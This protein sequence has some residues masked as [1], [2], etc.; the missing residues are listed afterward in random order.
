M[1]TAL[2]KYNFEE[3]KNAITNYAIILKDDNYYFSY[4]WTLGDFLKRGI[5]KF[6]DLE[7][8]KNNYRTDKSKPK[9][10]A[11]NNKNISGYDQFMEKVL[12]DRR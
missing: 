11:N 10:S 5:E 6:M 1:Q 12:N 8:A 7:I 3:V 9:F 2:N 4:R